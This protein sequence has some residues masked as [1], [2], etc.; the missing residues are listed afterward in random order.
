[1][2]GVRRTVFTMV[3]GD[4]EG[5]GGGWGSGKIASK[6]RELICVTHRHARLYRYRWRECII[7]CEICC[8]FMDD[9]AVTRLALG[10]QVHCALAGINP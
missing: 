4:G 8:L 5:G 3:Q 6:K 2:Y 1:M 10:C 9:P 7:S